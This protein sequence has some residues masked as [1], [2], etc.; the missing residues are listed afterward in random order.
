[1]PQQQ[2]YYFPWQP[3]QSHT[4][5][6]SWVQLNDDIPTSLTHSITLAH[7]AAQHNVVFA[8]G[9]RRLLP[10]Q[11]THSTLQNQPLATLLVCHL[12]HR[13]TQT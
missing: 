8:S 5:T 2:W 6:D 11:H 3:V 10:W 7:N 4:P 12:T 1:M 13:H 9:G